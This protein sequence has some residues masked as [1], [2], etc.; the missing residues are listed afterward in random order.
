MEAYN[1]SFGEGSEVKRAQQASEF[2][3]MIQA[4]KNR[5]TSLENELQQV[6]GEVKKLEQSGQL[7]PEELVDHKY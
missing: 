3:A 4:L 2:Q 7:F 6:K 5:I 1:I